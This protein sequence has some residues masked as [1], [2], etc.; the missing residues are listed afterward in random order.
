ML[1]QE[2]VELGGVFLDVAQVV[3]LQLGKGNLS[4][5]ETA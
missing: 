4:P 5:G 1:S 2:Q 3:Q